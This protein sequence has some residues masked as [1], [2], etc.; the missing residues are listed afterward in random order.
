MPRIVD[1]KARYYYKKTGTK[2]ASVIKHSD[3]FQH[4]DKVKQMEII[5]LLPSAGQLF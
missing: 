5:L 1:L 4:M 2:S 3:W